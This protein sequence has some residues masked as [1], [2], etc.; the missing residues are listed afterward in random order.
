MLNQPTNKGH[1]VIAI[2]GFARCG[3]D[4]LANMIIEQ[5]RLQDSK[6][7]VAE[8]KFA[9]QL[10]NAMQY[11]FDEIGIDVDTFTEYDALKGLLRPAFVEF[12][13]ACR[14]LNKDV[15]VDRL[16]E[17]VV[18]AT[19]ELKHSIVLVPDMRYTNEYDKLKKACKMNGWSFVPIYISR[20]GF[21]PANAEEARSFSE[22]LENDMYR[23]S[24]DNGLSL[25]FKDGDIESIRSYAK[26]FV[27]GIH[28]YMPVNRQ[29]GG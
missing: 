22:L 25:S 20:E 2:S 15:F 16:I 7:A 12:G 26:R 24:N 13:V 21:G 6:F 19:M 23:F 8:T 27:S 28:T 18:D 9:D 14:A 10:K 5:A 17:S 29:G 1:I 3:K 4:T 11:A